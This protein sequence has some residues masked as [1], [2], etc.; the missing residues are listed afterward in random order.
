MIQVKKKKK[1]IYSY[2]TA[3]TRKS[4]SSPTKWLLKEGFL[5]GSI[6]DFGCGKG[7]DSAFLKREGYDVTS[8]DPYWNPIDYSDKYYDVVICNY[9]LN[10][11]SK[12]DEVEAIKSIKD[13]LKPGGSAFISV[14]RDLKKE[15][16]TSRGFQRNVVLNLELL[17]E[18]R[19]SFAIYKVDN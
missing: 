4:L 2:N 16:W 17:Y 6:L 19:G 1:E 15:G 8:Y 14:R 13:S 5:D 3:I 9:V 11:L 12:E 7:F 18:K 10:V